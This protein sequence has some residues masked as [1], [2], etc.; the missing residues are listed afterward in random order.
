MK[1][2]PQFHSQ[3]TGK[4]TQA[5]SGFSQSGTSQSQSNYSLPSG[6]FGMPVSDKFF[7]G[8]AILANNFNRD[9]DQN[10]ILRYVMSDNNVQDIDFVPAIGFKLNNYLSI[11]AGLNFSHA[12]FFFT[13]ISG[14]P[15]LDIPDIQSDNKANANAW[16]GDLGIL[17]TPSSSTQIGLNYRSSMT[18]HFT[19]TSQLNS[20]PVITSNNF[21]FDYWTPTRY[22]LSV[23]QFLSQ[24]FGLIGTLQW[25]KW[26]IY[27]EMNVHGITT[28]IGLNPVILSDVTIPL[29]FHN[30]WIYTLGDYYHLSSK[31]VIRTAG[32]Y[33]QSPGNANYQITEGDNI[34]LGASIGYKLSKTISIDASYAH[35]FIQNQTINIQNPINTINGMNKSYRD[36]LSLKIIINV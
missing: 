14:L 28:Q 32:S 36:S 29:H 23:N 26:D 13:P 9:L 16:G 24:A 18:Y 17:L 30:G 7:F 11:G 8:L 27:D 15:S 12:N 31:W 19:G 1:G 10:S 21:S 25:I 6:Y 3:F 2:I 35:A 22:V 4:V 33:I 34:I 20:N 5:H